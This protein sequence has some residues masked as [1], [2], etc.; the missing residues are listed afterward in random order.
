MCNLREYVS[1]TTY[2]CTS[3]KSFYVQVCRLS[4]GYQ[5]KMTFFSL[6]DFLDY[7]VDSD[8]EWEEEEPG[9]SLSHSE[10]VSFFHVPKRVC[11]VCPLHKKPTAVLR[12]GIIGTRHERLAFR[13]H[14]SKDGI[15]GVL[16]TAFGKHKL[17][18]STCGKLFDWMATLGSKTSL[19]SSSRSSKTRVLE[20]VL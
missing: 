2:P 19:G 17:H 16:Y 10:G 18:R 7:E 4:P 20:D 1:L 9:E 11:E 13:N 12:S 8:E 14:P 6:Q 3:N 15:G 5:I